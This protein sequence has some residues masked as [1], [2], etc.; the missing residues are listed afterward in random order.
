MPGTPSH[1]TGFVM[2]RRFAMSY[3]L[4]EPEWPVACECTYSEDH[5]RMNREDCWIHCNIDDAGSS[6]ELTAAP[7]KPIPVPEH[8]QENAA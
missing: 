4:E 5:D 7:K 1:G 3:S 8:D 2:A 6:L